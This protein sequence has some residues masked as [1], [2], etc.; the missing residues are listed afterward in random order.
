MPNRWC[1]STTSSSRSRLAVC[2]PTDGS[3]IQAS[4]IPRSS[5]CTTSRSASF[6][7]DANANPSG[8]STA[9]LQLP[10]PGLDRSP[11]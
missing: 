6:A 4:L 7:N 9:M 8:T 3:T 5:A 2:S 11:R 10:P 1:T